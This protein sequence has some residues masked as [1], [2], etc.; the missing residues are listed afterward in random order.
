MPSNWSATR[1]K[2]H[3]IGLSKSRRR[4]SEPDATMSQSAAETRPSII[5]ILPSTRS[6]PSAKPAR[7]ISRAR[8]MRAEHGA[9]DA[10]RA[11]VIR[12]VR[13]GG[14]RGAGARQ[15]RRLQAQGDLGRWTR[16][17]RLSQRRQEAGN[18]AGGG[19]A[20]PQNLRG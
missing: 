8:P 13:A 4:R 12:P 11:A 14:D 5:L 3:S 1:A 9:A 15:D 17:A 19:G 10:Q 2:G 16:S 6:T 20:G 7:P 18:R